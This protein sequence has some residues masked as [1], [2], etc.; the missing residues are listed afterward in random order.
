M[1]V[2]IMGMGMVAAQDGS[3]SRGDPSGLQR[4]RDLAETIPGGGSGA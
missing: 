1:T 3:E 4:I 2:E